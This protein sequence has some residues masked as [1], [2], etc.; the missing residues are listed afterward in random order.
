MPECV[1]VAASAG[2]ALTEERLLGA[3]PQVMVGRLNSEEE[4]VPLDMFAGGGGTPTREGLIQ[5]YEIGHFIDLRQKPVG[6]RT[7]AGSGHL[8]TQQLD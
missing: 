6:K 5:Q 2:S 3:S 8:P 7:T 1:V 4:H